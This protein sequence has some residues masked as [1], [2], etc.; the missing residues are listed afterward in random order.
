MTKKN[1]MMRIAS[2]LLIAVV[3][4]TSVIG[5][6][7][8][9]YTSQANISASVTVAKWDVKLNGGTFAATT[10][11][12]FTETWTDSNGSAEEDVVSTPKKL[13]APGTKGS[14]NLIVKND[15]QVNA[16]FDITFDFAGLSTLPLNFTYKIGSNS[17]ASGDDIDLAIGETKTVTVEWEWPYEAVAPRTDADDTDLGA[18]AGTFIA[19][20][21]VVAWQ[22][23]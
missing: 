16:K 12:D 1:L 3:L 11:F 19:N 22:V 6:T 14:F 7:L 18:A 9:K 23:D 4:T 13:L 2:V 8:A 21:T 10:S 17:Y 20:A 15:S 5:G